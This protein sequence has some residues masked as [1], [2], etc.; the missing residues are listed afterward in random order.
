VVDGARKEVRKTLIL[1]SLCSK[2]VHPW[3]LVLLKET[4]NG[5]FQTTCC[6]SSWLFWA[7]CDIPSSM[8]YFMAKHTGKTKNTIGAKNSA[9]EMESMEHLRWRS[10]NRVHRRKC[11]C[12]TCCHSSESELSRSDRR[13]TR[14]THHRSYSRY[15][16]FSSLPLIRCATC[17]PPNGTRKSDNTPNKICTNLRIQETGFEEYQKL[18]YKQYIIGYHIIIFD[19]SI[20][21]W[22]MEAACHNILRDYQ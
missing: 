11:T 3:G 6:L 15:P 17:C 16:T 5:K 22:L 18:E 9:S 21:K 12:N 1:E 10:P 20:M 8:P 14:E 7:I 13:L 19:I 4:S 2:H